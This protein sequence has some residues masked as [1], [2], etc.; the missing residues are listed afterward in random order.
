LPA[1]RVST[2]TLEKRRTPLSPA[3][4]KDFELLARGSAFCVTGPETG[5]TIA[6]S[7]A[8]VAAPHSYRRYFPA[9]WLTFVR[10]AHVRCELDL[11]ST[12]GRTRLHTLPPQPLVEAFRHASLDVAAAV[13]SPPGAPPPP[14]FSVLALAEGDVADPV[15]AAVAI[16]GHE[17]DGDGGGDGGGSVRPVAVRGTVSL[18]DGPSR[19]FVATGDAETVMGMCGG[20]VVGADGVVGLLEGLVPRLREG[21]V[22]AGEQHRRVAGQS[23]YVSAAELRLFVADV[24]K[25]WIRGQRRQQL[26]RRRGL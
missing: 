4:Q 8:H 25:E 19:G 15:G 20:P 14:G 18:V 13:V 12:D 21:E 1:R 17:A 24:E 9:D 11:R 3:P 7:S 2:L 26:Q 22:A 5:A 10:D 16:H 6:L 23:V